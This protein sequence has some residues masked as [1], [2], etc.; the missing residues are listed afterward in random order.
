MT[1]DEI[2]TKVS[3]LAKEN[4]ANGLNCSESVFDA[5]CRAGLVDDG[6]GAIAMASGFGGGLGM[7]GNACGALCGAVMAVGS[8]HGRK[9]PYSIPEDERKTQMAATGYRPFN[10]LTNDFANAFGGA[11]CREITSRFED[12]TSKERRAMCLDLVERTAGI[13]A[14]YILMDDEQAKSLPYGPNIAGKK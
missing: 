14:G 12:W 11:N 13:A 5:L 4:F 3:A 9:K 2:K 1:V 7:T 10:N 6:E 8:A